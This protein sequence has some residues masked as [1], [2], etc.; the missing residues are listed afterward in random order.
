MRERVFAD[1]QNGKKSAA[2][3]VNSDEYR[4]DDGSPDEGW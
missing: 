1:V 3:P 4:A 2:L